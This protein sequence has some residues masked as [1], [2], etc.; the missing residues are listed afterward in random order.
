MQDRRPSI[1]SEAP[2][3]QQ[4]TERW[5]RIAW[6]SCV[7]AVLGLC[8]VFGF[9][10]VPDS[11]ARWFMRSTRALVL[12]GPPLGFSSSALPSLLVGA[13]G[14]ATLLTSLRKAIFARS[15]SD[16]SLWSAVVV[17]VWLVFGFLAAVPQV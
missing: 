5:R 15:G 1:D 17:L 7:A 3:S 2:S 12:L 11:F 9:D 10:L 14:V 8:L 6:S 4:P 13:V 16:A